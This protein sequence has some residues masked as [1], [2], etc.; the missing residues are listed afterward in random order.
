M[1]NYSQ[2]W[3]TG[4]FDFPTRAQ[5]LRMILAESVVQGMG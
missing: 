5:V 3:N 2:K 1:N 4:V